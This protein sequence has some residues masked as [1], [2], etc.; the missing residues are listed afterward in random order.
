[1]FFCISG[2]QSRSAMPSTSNVER[3][4]SPVPTFLAQPLLAEAR[5]NARIANM[6]DLESVAPFCGVL[7]RR[8]NGIFEHLGTAWTVGPGEWVTAWEGEAPGTDVTLM[9]VQ[10]GTVSP[11]A[12]WECE[13]RIAG[14][15][16]QRRDSH[17]MV[18]REAALSK[19]MR[20]VAVGY[21]CMIDHPSFL[22]HRGSLDAVRYLPYLCP[23]T[24]TGHM[25]LFSSDDGYLTGRF[26]PGMAGGP[27]LDDELRVVGI[28][29]D[30]GFAP[31]HPPLTRFRRL[32]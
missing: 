1:M 24:I 2:R 13:N 27:V 10:D 4:V 18:E 8:A 30:G 12:D 23:W 22:L 7:L 5:R 19:R 26:Y 16:S 29:L 31:E 6:N 28:L 15:T 17:L 3:A 25:G 32:A 11:I 9:S 14:F 21:P 20:L